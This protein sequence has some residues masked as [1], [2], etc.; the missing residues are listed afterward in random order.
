[1]VVS[2]VPAKVIGVLTY[3]QGVF[4]SFEMDQR[5]SVCGM[6]MKPISS[7]ATNAENNVDYGA[8]I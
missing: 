8:Y 7:D 2:G 1:M 4:P 6:F 5:V 3:Q